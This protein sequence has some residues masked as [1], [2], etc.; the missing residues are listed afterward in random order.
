MQHSQVNKH[1][2]NIILTVQCTK[3]ILSLPSLTSDQMLSLPEVGDLGGVVVI[4]R[5]HAAILQPVCCCH[6][7]ALHLHRVHSSISA[8]L[9]DHLARHHLPAS[10]RSISWTIQVQCERFNGVQSHS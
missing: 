1:N 2:V 3:T 8:Q 9:Q 6:S 5:V 7:S 10:E 4:N